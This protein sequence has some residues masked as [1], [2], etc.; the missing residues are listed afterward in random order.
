M[1]EIETNIARKLR[2]SYQPALLYRQASRRLGVTHNLFR[3]LRRTGVLKKQH[4]TMMPQGIAVRDLDDFKQRVFAQARRVA[5]TEG[6][7]SLD[8]LRL[9][10]CPRAA[11]IEILRGILRGAIRPAY[12]GT[13]PQRIND[14]LVH[15]GEVEPIIA[16]FAPK[17]LPT[18]QELQTR[19]DLGGAEMRT[20]VR[21]LSGTPDSIS[22][23]PPNTIDVAKLR[24]FMVRYCGLK[25]YARS[26]Q[27]GYRATLSRLRHAGTEMLQ[28]PAAGGQGRFVYF[29]PRRGD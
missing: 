7:E 28:M 23:L 6:L 5:S 14:L 12:V 3:D 2:I 15:P 10:K 13:A 1:Y 19:Y 17:R 16:K 9:S 26:Q 21:Y 20:L 27:A 8:R 4:E 25:A 24:G 22:R 29:V 18:L 11:M